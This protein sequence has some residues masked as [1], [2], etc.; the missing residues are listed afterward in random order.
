MRS[1]EFNFWFSTI[2]ARGLR[3][4]LFIYIKH[5]YWDSIFKYNNFLRRQRN[6][7]VRQ[8]QKSKLDWCTHFSFHDI[9]ESHWL[10]CVHLFFYSN[11]NIGNIFIFINSR[12]MCLV[13]TLVRNIY[14]RIARRIDSIAIRCVRVIKCTDDWC[15]MLNGMHY[16]FFRVQSVFVKTAL[17]KQNST[18]I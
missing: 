4:F 18:V 17:M 15:P 13:Q 16:Y 10:L 3:V 2:T 9:N 11:R 6:V 7:L 12:T 5:S 14:V 1:I 8:Q